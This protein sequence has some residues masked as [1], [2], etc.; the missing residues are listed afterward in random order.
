MNVKRASQVPWAVPV[1]V[2]LC[3]TGFRARAKYGGGA[4]EPSDPYQ[5]ATAADLIALGETAADYNR[6]LLRTADI[7][8]D[9]CL[10]GHK[11]FDKAVIPAKRGLQGASFIGILNGNGHSILGAFRGSGP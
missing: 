3:L 2:A 7:D 5:I 1:P 10:R 11:V 6:H 8:L 9:T 4:G